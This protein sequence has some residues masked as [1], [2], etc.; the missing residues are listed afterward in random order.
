MRTLASL[1]HYVV[2]S[3]A[4]EV[5][6]HQFIP[7]RWTAEVAGGE[8]TLSV[9]TD[10]PWQGQVRVSV[11]A[12][13]GGGWGLGV[14][15]PEWART[16]EATV[17]GERVEA[18]AREGWLSVSREWAV[19]DELVLELPLDVRFTRADP[20]VDVNRGAVAIER[21]PLVYCL[22]AVDNPGQRLDDVILDPSSDASLGKELSLLGGIATVAARGHRRDRAHT[23]WW[24]YRA[25]A[26]AADGA[27]GAIE[28]TA[29]PYFVW[30]NREAGSMRVWV[31]AE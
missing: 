6:V 2:L 7:G 23:G 10:Y 12:A 22:E 17:N 29:V 1:E 5:R 11:A 13:P 20:R 15:V 27:G 3:S 28:L 9:E 21:G 8:A 18:S 24:P 30:G 14:R 4:D 25:D 31:P 19:G 26:R 16:A